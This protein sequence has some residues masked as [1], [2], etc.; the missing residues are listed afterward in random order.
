MNEV[1]KSPELKSKA[2]ICL[3]NG[4]VLYKNGDI[5]GARRA[6][7]DGIWNFINNKDSQDLH[8]MLSARILECQKALGDQPLIDSQANYLERMVE[9]PD[10]AKEGENRLVIAATFAHMGDSD[11]ATE[12]LDAVLPVGF[13]DQAIVR[14][15]PEIATLRA[16]SPRLEERLGKLGLLGTDELQHSLAA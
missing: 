12:E 10:I 8:L 4:D 14:L 3:E 11:A 6:Y 2:E 13:D 7:L 16:L 1:L 5:T 15:Q 9:E